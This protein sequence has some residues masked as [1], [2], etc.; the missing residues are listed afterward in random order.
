ANSVPFFVTEWGWQQ[1]GNTPTSGTLSGYGIPFSTYLES[2]G[3]SWTAWVFDQWWQPV[4]FDTSYNLLGGENYMGQ[5][6]KDFL[7]QHRNDNLPGGGTGP[8]NTPTRTPTRT[9]TPSGPTNTP[10]GPTTLRVQYR[11]ADTSA[12]D[13]QIKPHFNIRNTGTGSVPLSELKIRYWFTR[14]GSASQNFYCD[15]SGVGGGCSNV[16]GTF[17][18]VSPAQTGA[19]FYLEVGF[20]AAAGSI[21][22][23]GQSGE[24][25]ARVAKS[26]WSNYTETGDYSFDPT[27][28]A[29]ADW[30]RVTLYRNGTLVWGTPP[31]GT[32]PTNTPITPSPGTVTVTPS[33]TNTPTGPTFTPTRTPTRTNT[34]S[35]PTF[36]PTRTPTPGTGNLKI[37]VMSG[38]TDNN[39]QSAFRY[40]VQNTGAS[41]LSNI[42][43]R[44]YFTTDGSNAASG[45]LLEKYYDQSGVATLSGPT[46]FSGTTYYFTVNYGTASLPAG[47]SWEYQTSLHLNSWGS[48]YS[49]T[50]DWWHGTGTLPASYSD[51][52]TIPAY[53][54]GGR[55]WGS[56][57]G[58][59]PLPTFTPTRTNTPQGP[60]NTPTR[61]PTPGGPTNTPTRTP[62]NPP[63]G[64]HLDNPFVG[65]TFYRNVDYT[66]S[67]N[68][69]ANLQGGTLAPLMRQVANYPTFV[70][71]DSIA[72]VNG[73]NGYPRSLAGHL[74]QALLQG[75][76][77]IGI[78]VY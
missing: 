78:V 38:G 55:V 28:T 2:K 4:M 64:T 13:N 35:G 59:T 25:Q 61:T 41:A 39:Q 51:W 34:P 46:Q 22:A 15:W 10:S 68:A 21:P 27:K 65:A 36:T 48:T 40:R 72:A 33:R 37:Q 6:T 66:A 42:T 5:F 44:I 50:N 56:E 14:E 58:G 57:P 49:G 9:N 43:V 32:G 63:P 47:Q 11:A 75:A 30:D 76:N 70:W 53:V 29:F 8:T 1:G 60:T 18:A 24:I 7:Y 12:T 23:G 69:A 3:L 71:L 54:S 26:D 16:T 19:N 73:T 52:T 77:A 67:V 31:G 74:D 17:V 45:Y 20:S 62:T